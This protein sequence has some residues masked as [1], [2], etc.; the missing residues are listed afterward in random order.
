MPGAM[1]SSG[2]RKKSTSLEVAMW[3]T[4]S[5]VGWFG[6]IA[7]A[8]AGSSFGSQC[9]VTSTGAWPVTLLVMLVPAAETEAS[10]V[11]EPSVRP[12]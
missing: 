7:G 5:E 8:V 12:A 3:P 1:P 2:S 6:S 10:A 11:C 9:C 4:M